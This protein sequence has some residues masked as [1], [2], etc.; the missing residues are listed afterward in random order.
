MTHAHDTEAAGAHTHTHDGFDWAARL[1]GL[2]RADA[3][4]AGALRTVAGRL[5][6]T[7]GRGATVVDVGSGAGGMSAH[8]GLALRARG[9]GT[10]VLVD[11]VPELLEAAAEH[12]HQAVDGSAGPAVEVR[13]VL[14]DAAGD[15][16]PEQVPAA[17]LVWAS[18]VVHHLRDQQDGVNRLTRLLTPG[19]TL[20]LAEGGLGTQCLPWDLGIGEPGLTNRVVAA[21]NQWFTRLRADIPGSVRLPVGWTRALADAGLTEVT[22]FSYL[23][24]HPAPL[25]EEVREAVVEWL[26]FMSHAAGDWLSDDDNHALARLLDPTDPAF[27]G[28][29]D[30]VFYLASYSVHLGRRPGGAG[31][32]AQPPE[33]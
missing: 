30:D 4:D 6:A 33:V 32:P 16:L 17:D 26:E 27:A 5:T 23:V 21:R 12:V 31:Q 9:G 22:S 13:T 18:H 8:L 10:L 25:S 29:R 19:G 14:A 15:R 1:T 2:R 24:D 28:A 7:V 11:A 20:A 3:I